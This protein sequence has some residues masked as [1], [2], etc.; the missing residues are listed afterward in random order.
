MGRDPKQTLHIV[1]WFSVGPLAVA[2]TAIFIGCAA[3]ER[4]FEPKPT[5]ALAVKYCFDTSGHITGSRP[6]IQGGTCC[7][8]PTQELLEQYQADGFCPG[9]TLEELIGLYRE[10]GIKTA[11]DHQGCNNACRWGPHVL[12]GGTCLVPPTAGTK[13]Y[14]EIATGM[15]YVP[16]PPER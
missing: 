5:T 14:E 13:N 16:R 2:W 7:G 1:R 6:W 3:R 12:K 8:T 15:R 10:R 11:L 4:P 9:M